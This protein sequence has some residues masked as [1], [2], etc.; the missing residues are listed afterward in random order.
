MRRPLGSP[1]QKGGMRPIKG[2][3]T[4]FFILFYPALLRISRAK[5]GAGMH[6]I[7]LLNASPFPCPFP[8]HAQAG[9]SYWIENSAAAPMSPTWSELRCVTPK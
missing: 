2:R 4:A 7:F 9:F 5:A 8:F 6:G 3:H 1:A